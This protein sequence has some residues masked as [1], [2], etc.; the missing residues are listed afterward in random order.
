MLNRHPEEYPRFRDCFIQDEEHP[1]YDDHI[2][3]Y[4]RV[5]GNNRK[6]WTMEDIIS[7]PNFVATYDD[8]F[9]NT[10]G[11]YV[12]K[13]PDQWRADFELIKGGRLKDVSR[14]YQEQVKKIYPKLKQKLE[15][16][17]P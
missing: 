10:F 17:W 13:V 16:M 4:T 12:F 9:D 8:S 6:N 1:E 15:E 2:L 14:E 3:V 5:G 11:M 7:D